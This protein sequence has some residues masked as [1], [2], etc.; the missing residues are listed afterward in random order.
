MR[1]TIVRILRGILPALLLVAAGAAYPHP[2]GASPVSPI[3]GGPGGAAA[4]SDID[5]FTDVTA[6]QDLDFYRWFFF[7]GGALGAHSGTIQGGM[8]A[9]LYP[10]YVAAFFNGD[11]FSGTG[12]AADQDNPT[13]Q[14]TANQVYHETAWNDD[15]VLFI[16]SDFLGGFRFELLFDNTEFVSQD[17]KDGGFYEY[18][19][20]FL[21]SLQ[22]GRRFGGLDAKVTT[23]VGWGGYESW[24]E[25]QGTDV[26]STTIQD[27]TMLGIKLEAAYGGF[28]ADYQFS[29][30]LGREETVSGASDPS[31][32]STT[33]F[34][35]GSVEQMI[36][37]YYTAAIP[38]SDGIHLS[39]RPRLL[40]G[41]YHNDYERAASGNTYGKQSS[42]G[43]SPLLEAELGYQITRKIFVATSLSFNAFTASFAKT[44]A[45]AYWEIAGLTVDSAGSGDLAFR[46][47]FSQSFTLEAGIDGLF[48]FS[49][50]RYA[51]DFSNLHGG[52]TFIFKPGM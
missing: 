40:L 20:P 5:L 24:T 32:N 8:A 44:D 28:A 52:F 21:T 43:F 10:L 47:A 23:G 19:G 26:V 37:L 35:V 45:G 38:V 12:S 27:Y 3:A 4:A 46:F 36:N 51:L 7:S 6:W 15:L 22:W 48:D 14:G 1:P 31:L 13:Y 41:F 2:H 39:L 29:I 17:E 49:R 11:V 50:A 25:T 30:G 34:A 9:L 18:R 42:F 16:G 33:K